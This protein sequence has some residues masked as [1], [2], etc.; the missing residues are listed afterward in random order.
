MCSDVG[1][2]R[3]AFSLDMR[4]GVPVIAKAAAIPVHTPEI[5][6]ASAVNAG[7]AALIVLDLERV[8]TGAGVDLSLLG[9][10]RRTVP[11]VMLLAGG[12]VR[13][14]DDLLR[15]EDVGCDAALV[16]TALHSGAIDPR[17]RP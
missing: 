17:A 15:L 8:G 10:V 13:G 7:A 3:V 14:W 6:A 16:A 9:A 12:G 2:G 11:G 5:I 4:G 1:G